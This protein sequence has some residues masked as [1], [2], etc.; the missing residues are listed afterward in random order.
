M[1]T[2]KSNTFKY[3]TVEYEFDTNIDDKDKV[4]IIV[5]EFFKR[6]CECNSTTSCVCN[7]RNFRD[8]LYKFF[9]YIDFPFDYYDNY[10]IKF[11]LET[12]DGYFYNGSNKMTEN[13]TSKKT[14]KEYHKIL[15]KKYTYMYIYIK[16]I[17]II[18]FIDTNQTS[19]LNNLIKQ[20]SLNLKLLTEKINVLEESITNIKSMTLKDILTKSLHTFN[21]N[22]LVLENKK[23]ELIQQ[24]KIYE[25][26][27]IKQQ[28][29]YDK[30]IIITNKIKDV[31]EKMLELAC[32]E[33]PP[34]I[35][36]ISKLEQQLNELNENIDDEL[37]ANIEIIRN[38]I[39][40]IDVNIE[41]I[42]K[43]I[44]KMKI[45]E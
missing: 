4:Y 19:K 10:D 17:G 8:G 36:Y 2:T 29:L 24:L 27:Y 35:I 21:E 44:E 7:G 25:E 15:S 23:Q 45:I 40:N 34:F 39:N 22:K 32:D 43:D 1:Q 3:Y 14:Y 26:K 42:L 9:N 37:N 41:I 13:K 16:K 5:E 28:D 38:N 12:D 33:I 18:V 11:I 6:C 31:N 20:Q 30:R